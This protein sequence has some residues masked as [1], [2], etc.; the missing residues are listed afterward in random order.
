[1]ENVFEDDLY[2]DYKSEMRAGTIKY[3]YEVNSLI[4]ASEDVVQKSRK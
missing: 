2:T 4:G 1:M 3:V